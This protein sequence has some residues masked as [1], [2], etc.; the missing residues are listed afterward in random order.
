MKIF[1]LPALLVLTSLAY[2]GARQDAMVVMDA[3]T[4]KAKAQTGWEYA[5][6]VPARARG[7]TPG[8]RRV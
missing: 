6:I 7:L 1:I 4:G 3:G 8:R 2:A 5:S